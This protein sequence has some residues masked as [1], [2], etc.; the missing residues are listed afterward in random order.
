MTTACLLCMFLLI[1]PA[2]G[3]IVFNIAERYVK[4]DQEFE[5]AKMD[6]LFQTYI[7]R[8]QW[9][10]VDKTESAYRREER[11]FMFSIHL[12]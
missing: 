9:L 12:V 5:L 3:A 6:N 8:G 7:D 11:C 10:K 2:G 4:S 1:L